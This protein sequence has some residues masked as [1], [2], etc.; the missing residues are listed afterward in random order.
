MATEGFHRSEESPCVSFLFIYLF[1]IAEPLHGY[2]M[3]IQA[4]LMNKPKT[5]TLSLTEVSEIYAPLL[6]SGLV[7]ICKSFGRFVSCYIRLDL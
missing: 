7:G 1:L 3:C 2:R 5:A 6:S 4:I